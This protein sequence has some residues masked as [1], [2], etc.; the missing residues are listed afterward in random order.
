MANDDSSINDSKLPFCP[1]PYK[2]VN[3]LYAIVAFIAAL[4]SLL[5]TY[6]PFSAFTSLNL[7][8]LL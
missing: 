4:T 2:F 7:F 5:F 8:S 6:S 1:I 3:S